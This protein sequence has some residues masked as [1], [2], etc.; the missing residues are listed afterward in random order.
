MA[1]KNG[2]VCCLL[3]V[4]LVH[5]HVAT[6]SSVADTDPSL[7]SMASSLLETQQILATVQSSLA[8]L[9]R[10]GNDFHVS[11]SAV[12][13]SVTALREQQ[14]QLSN[15]HSDLRVSHD[16]L[17]GEHRQLRAALLSTKFDSQATISTTTF[18]HQSMAAGNH[19]HIDQRPPRRLQGHAMCDMLDDA[20]LFVEGAGVF[21]GDV[22]VG[23]PQSSLTA[24]VF[25]ATDTSVAVDAIR[26]WMCL[27]PKS[28]NFVKEFQPLG[29]PSARGLEPFS[30]GVEHFLAVADYYNGITHA[31]PSTV[32]RFNADTVALELYQELETKGARDWEHFTIDNMDFLAVANHFNDGSYLV[33]SVVYCYNTTTGAFEA[34]QKIDTLGARD[35]EH[36]R[37][38]NSN[39][40]AIANSFD[41]L[42]HEISSVVYRYNTTTSQ[43]DPFQEIET[44]GA[45]D[46]E[47][48]RVAGADFLVVANH[49]SKGSYRQKSKVYQYNEDKATFDVVQEID[50]DGGI[51][52]EH[53]VIG[54]ETFIVI[55]N[56]YNDT[57][58]HLRSTV[59]RYNHV[60]RMF[61]SFQEIDT[62]GAHNWEH[63]CIGQENFL[64]V[65]NHRD[66]NSY[67][68]PSVVY[69]YD[70]TS[71]AFKV[72]RYINTTGVR[73]W[74]HFRIG[75]MEFLAFG[76][77][78]AGASAGS[79][80]VMLC[81]SVC[82]T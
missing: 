39:F 53:F 54:N 67:D 58:Y 49:N 64:V 76:E 26:D 13:A 10:Q 74:Q 41:G 73:E 6:A 21:M 22:L 46:W 4:A 56:F 77:Y 16:T 12:D 78:G 47:H 70:N 45:Y 11:L 2:L 72:F 24:T 75:T 25:A 30:I 79:A 59:Y 61:E 5:Q 69:R 35:W 27:P 31:L 52:W 80:S 19:P 15:A 17:S 71:A 44:A 29:T 43:L 9:R 8:R 82:F 38:G 40:L 63:F 57:S 20:G 48:V 42:S 65:A 68:I 37:I 60:V 3:V 55:A 32:Y 1:A 62:I 23:D 7:A 14:V 34:F 33:E 18:H 51:D 66:S 81:N 36:F 50:T 28:F